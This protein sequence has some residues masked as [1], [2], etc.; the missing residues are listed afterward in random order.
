MYKYNIVH[1][2]V[3]AVGLLL[4]RFFYKVLLALN[5]NYTMESISEKFC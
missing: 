5:T 4:V 3:K 2:Y 1:F